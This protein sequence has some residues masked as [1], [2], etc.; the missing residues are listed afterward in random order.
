L[1]IL[2]SD[3]YKLILSDQIQKQ[4]EGCNC[5]CKCG[6]RHQEHKVFVPNVHIVLTIYKPNRSF[7]P[8]LE[9]GLIFPFLLEVPGPEAISVARA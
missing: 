7:V 6:F 8:S 1:K 9:V 2:L 3:Y 5:H 4:T